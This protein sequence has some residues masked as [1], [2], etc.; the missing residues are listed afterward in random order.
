MREMAER[1]SG[2]RSSSMRMGIWEPGAAAVGMRPGLFEEG[3][4]ELEVL[5]GVGVGEVY[6]RL[7]MRRTLW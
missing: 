4:L 3:V 1:F 2:F 7:E 6:H 5:S